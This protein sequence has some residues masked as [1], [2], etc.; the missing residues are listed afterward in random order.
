MRSLSSRNIGRLEGALIPLF[1]AAGLGVRLH[2]SNEY[3]SSVLSSE[4]GATVGLARECTAP[5]LAKSAPSDLDVL[6]AAVAKSKIEAALSRQSIPEARAWSEAIVGAME[7]EAYPLTFSK[8]AA[9]MAFLQQESSFQEDPRLDMRYELKE[10]RAQLYEAYPVLKDIE[11]SDVFEAA[12]GPAYLDSLEARALALN[13]ERQAVDLLHVAIDDAHEFLS[14]HWMLGQF[15]AGSFGSNWDFYALDVVHSVG[16]AQLNPLGTFT[17]EER[18][19]LT[20]DQLKKRQ[21]ELFDRKVAVRFLVRRLKAHQDAYGTEFGKVIADYKGGPFASLHSQFQHALRET[22]APG[23]SLDGDLV[24]YT[25]RALP[26]PEK[27]SSTFKAALKFNEEYE[28]GFSRD[29]IW[30]ALSSTGVEFQENCFVRTTIQRAQ[31]ESSTT[32]GEFTLETSKG[33]DSAKGKQT[34]VE[35]T[36]QVWSKYRFWGN[37]LEDKTEKPEPKLASV[38][39]TPVVPRRS[40]VGPEKEASASVESAPRVHKEIEKTESELREEA[41]RSVQRGRVPMPRPVTSSYRTPPPLYMEVAK[42]PKDTESNTALRSMI[43]E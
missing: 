3:S 20:P 8:I 31:M 21:L 24:F 30:N 4:G 18:T 32:I 12:G 34:V 35:Y 43:G 14:E 29:E 27:E 42:P 10:K 15:V 1:F 36:R 2:L 22:V 26:D 11:A 37:E 5:V 6:E 40:I 7:E 25:G 9:V 17:L 13:S 19:S 33:G 39:T 16:P 23:L 38:S 41:R 28:L